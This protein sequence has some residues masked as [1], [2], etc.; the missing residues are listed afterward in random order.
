[1]TR[2]AVQLG[3]PDLQAV[4]RSGNSR[5]QRGNSFANFVVLPRTSSRVSCTDAKEVFEMSKNTGAAG[6]GAWHPPSPVQLRLGLA[7]TARTTQ[8]DQESGASALKMHLACLPHGDDELS[9]EELVGEKSTYRS[10]QAR[11]RSA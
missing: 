11:T 6:R 2:R 10:V 5:R 4:E 9:S 7:R 3:A 8:L 1:M